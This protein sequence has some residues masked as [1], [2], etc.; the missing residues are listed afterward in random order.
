MAKKKSAPPDDEDLEIPI[1]KVDEDGDEIIDLDDWK[2]NLEEDLDYDLTK[3]E[4]DMLEDETE[5]E[6]FGYEISEVEALLR[7]VK[8]TPCPGS[9]SKRECKVRDDFGCPPDKAK[10]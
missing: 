4:D 5:D 8:C 3:I 10:K 9:S 2:D 6:S 1:G 7:K